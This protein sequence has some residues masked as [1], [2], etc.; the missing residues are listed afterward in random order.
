MRPINPLA[1][2]SEKS[3]FTLFF[4]QMAV[5]YIPIE[6]E[7]ISMLKVVM[8]AFSGCYLVIGFKLS[9][10]FVLC[11]FYWLSCLFF[12][13]LHIYIFRWS[14]IL[15][16]GLFLIG[17]SAFVNSLYSKAFTCEYFLNLL[18]GIIYAYFIFLIIQQFYSIVLGGGRMLLLNY[19][20][21]DEKPNMLSLEVSHAARIIGAFMLC[22][23]RLYELEYGRKLTIKEIFDG[24][25]ALFLV[26]MYIMITMG[27]GTAVMTLIILS[28][29]FMSARNAI[30]V[31]VALL[32]CYSLTD[33]IDYEPLQRAK[34][35]FEASLTGDKKSIG[36]ADGSAA[37]RVIPLLNTF[38]HLDLMSIS[39]WIGKGIDTTYNTDL[40][41]GTK[42][43]GT[44]S[45]YGLISYVLSLSIFFIIC[46][47]K[48]L[49]VETL[50]F[51]FICLT[52]ISNIA[53]YWSIYMAFAAVHYFQKEE[54]V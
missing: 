39:T 51:V 35:T 12:A 27:S 16:L 20:G 49:S 41:L 21:V 4:I 43:V 5:V 13:Q 46:V 42:Y 10:V 53:F 52:N 15:Y 9:K 8:L 31:F 18:K 38:L 1:I 37:Y 25:K 45:D 26:F 28:L 50:F 29:Y 34:V 24:D 47:R 30:I 14:T 23:V 44:L 7:A 19:T 32:V 17:F 3:F 36:R 48:I 6:G 40:F 11:A 22:V 54:S 33:Y 2:I